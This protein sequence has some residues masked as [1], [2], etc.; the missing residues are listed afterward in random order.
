[1][2]LLPPEF[3][4]CVVGTQARVPGTIDVEQLGTGLI[5]LQDNVQSEEQAR[6]FLITNRHLVDG[7]DS[8][9]LVMDG[10]DEF[11]APTL[12]ID[13]TDGSRKLIRNP[14]G[15]DLV[16]IPL[17]EGALNREMRGVRPIRET[18]C[19]TAEMVQDIGVAEG[20]GIFI[21]TLPAGLEGLEDLVGP[22][23]KQGCIARIG[24]YISGKANHILIDANITHGNSGSPVFL[25]PTEFAVPGTKSNTFPYLL[26]L[27]EGAFTYEEP[28]ASVITGRTRVVFEE[29]SGIVRVVSSDDILDTVELARQTL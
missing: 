9:T 14:G 20:D 11:S 23:V 4:R 13:L 16:A 28:A 1:M 24:Q 2:A 8:V 21:V 6:R 5:F 19:L 26:G 17:D 27:I 10:D 18:E 3:L 25:K 12:R 29:Q 22:V 7:Y 15:L